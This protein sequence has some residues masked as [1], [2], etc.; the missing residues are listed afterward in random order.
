MTNESKK[1][2]KTEQALKNLSAKYKKLEYSAMVTGKALK[3][4]VPALTTQNAALLLAEL[5]ELRDYR[6]KK[7]QEEEIKAKAEEEAAEAK[8][9]AEAAENGKTP[10]A[11]A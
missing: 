6:K 9:E 5:D 2:K 1:L 3:V 11:G 7:M 4:A 10:G 8:E